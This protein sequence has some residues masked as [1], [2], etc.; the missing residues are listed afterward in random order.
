MTWQV[1]HAL[2]TS[3]ESTT[4]LPD[5]MPERLGCLRG[6]PEK[7]SASRALIHLQ[8]QWL[9][10]CCYSRKCYSCLLSRAKT[11]TLKHALATAF[12]IPA[13]AGLFEHPFCCLAQ[14]QLPS[15]S[16]PASHTITPVRRGDNPSPARGGGGLASWVM[17]VDTCQKYSPC[18]EK[19]VCGVT[20]AC[21]PWT[22]PPSHQHPHNS[23]QPRKS[24]PAA[25]RRRQ[26]EGSSAVLCWDKCFP[27]CSRTSLHSYCPHNESRRLR[28]VSEDSDYGST[29]KHQ[30]KN[31]S[32]VHHFSIN[33]TNMHKTFRLFVKMRPFHL[34]D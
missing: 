27:S 19:A 7:T 21:L 5:Q 33:P 6:S 22:L 34:I 17:S 10:T 8:H 31:P 18:P 24:L 28:S 13:A 12:H 29:H 9:W 20:A 25:A 4:R 14:Q 30:L 2:N 15:L 11:P 16:W 32:A 26:Q 3:T 23:I 1:G